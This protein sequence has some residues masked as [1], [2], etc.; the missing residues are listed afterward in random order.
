MAARRGKSQA[1]R[2]GGDSN[3]AWIWLFAGLALGIALIVGVPKLMP[4]GEGDGFFRP[5]P[6]PDAQP[7]ATSNAADDDAL[8][9]EDTRPAPAK[10]DKPKETQYD[11]YTLL[12]S[13]EVALSDAELAET[14][15]AEAQRQAAIAK[16]QS[17]AQQPATSPDA[18]TPAQQPVVATNAN[19]TPAMQPTA[20]TASATKPEPKDDGA[21]YILQAGA[22]QASGDAEAVKAKIALLGLSARVESATISDK[23]VFRVR[24]GPYGSASELADAK[25]RLSGGGLPAMAIKAR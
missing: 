3:P 25:R 9:P 12:P 18:A 6:N 21:H 17:A 2:N 16:Q 11:F 4:K 14:E 19:A 24:M 1:K 23:T 10:A 20:T 13:N 7:V 22:F 8:V 5:K 15:R